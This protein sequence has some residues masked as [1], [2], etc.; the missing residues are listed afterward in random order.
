MNTPRAPRR[1]LIIEDDRSLREGLAMNFSLRGHTVLTA[2]DGTKGL[3]MAFGEH[4]DL[5][6]LDLT[7]PGCDGLDLLF[8]LRD[9][10]NQVPVL[11]L[12]ARDS[13]S[14]KVE[15]LEVGADDYLPKPFHLPELLARVEALLRRHPPAAPPATLQVGPVTLDLDTHRATLRGQP[16]KLS[17]REFSLLAFLAHAPG[18][19]FSREQILEQVWGWEFEGTPRTVDNYILALRR[20]LEDDPANPRHLITVRQLG[21]RLDP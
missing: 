21:Y 20:L 14:Q 10:G 16:L 12:S 8:E 5:L 15:G 7:L 4:P 1:I 3:A 6:I 19:V 13:V 18:K 11:I 9:H 17:A 2:A